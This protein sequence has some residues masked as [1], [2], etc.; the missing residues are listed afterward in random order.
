MNRFTREV[1]VEY[2]PIPTPPLASGREERLWAN[3]TPP[4]PPMASGREE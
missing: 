3:V 2:S 1:G 4:T